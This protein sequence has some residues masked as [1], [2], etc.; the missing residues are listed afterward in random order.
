MDEK[1]NL[2]R[3]RNPHGYNGSEWNGDWRWWRF[4]YRIYIKKTKF[5]IKISYNSKKWDTIDGESEKK[6]KLL[7]KNDGEFWMSFDDFFKNYD[8]LSFVHVNLNAYTEQ[9][10][11]S[12][13]HLNWNSK[14]I[15]GILKKE[16]DIFS[17]PHHVV[18]LNDSYTK[19]RS[20]II[21]IMTTNYIEKRIESKKRSSIAFYLYK[22]SDKRAVL[23]RKYGEDELVLENKSG[24]YLS[25]REVTK[26]FNLNPGLY[27]IIPSTT[28][29]DETGYLLR[30]FTESVI[31]AI[32]D[33]EEDDDDEDLEEDEEEEEE[34][35][36]D[37]DDDENDEDDEDEYDDEDEDEEEEGEE[38]Y[39]KHNRK[40]E[41]K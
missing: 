25:Q 37:N 19:S 6:L 20:I 40:Y 33:D 13:A 18:N 26:R 35:G 16:E 23:K 34:E 7:K 38:D 8:R 41:N 9:A 36:D 12:G 31:Y 15:F 17:N 14:Q 2:I 4:N 10:E 21:S 27:V 3:I 22:I 5:F 24:N 28:E 29:A 39:E 11:S 32:N 30:I 1:L